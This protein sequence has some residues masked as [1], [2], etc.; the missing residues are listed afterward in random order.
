[1]KKL[2]LF[3]FI[4]FIVSQSYSQFSRYIIYFKNKDATTFSLSNPSA[5]LSQRSI[6]RRTKYAIAIDSSDLPVPAT[7]IL[8]VKNIAGVTVL[9][10]SRWLNAI[11]VSLSN[12][13]LL[14]Q[15]EAL[16]F[17]KKTNAIAARSISTET[18]T[19]DEMQ[20]LNTN[21]QHRAQNTEGNYF[22]YGSSSLSEMHLHKGEF[23]HNIG[24]RG[25][26]MQIAVIDGGFYQYNT[27]K[28][29]DSVNAN[30]QILDTWDFVTGDASV[31][32]D[33]SHGMSCL[34]TI[35]AN[36][37][38]QFIGTAPKAGFRLYRSEDAASE[39]PVEEFNFICAAERA[40]SSGVNIISC[41]LGY[42][43]FTNSTFNYTYADMN[44]DKTL[45][46][47]GADIAAKKG[48]LLFI[49]AGNSGNDA[50]K[51]IVTPADADSVLTV[52]AVNTAG[53]PGSFSSYG[54]SSDGRVKPDIASVGVSAIVQT[55]S[56]T[57][58]ISN[59]TSYACPKMAG[60]GT[61][62]WQGFPEFT[63]M[64]IVQVIKEAGS[65]YNTPDNRIGYGIPDMKKAFSALLSRFST[66]NA[67]INNCTATLNWT[68]KDVQGMRYEIERK[69]P[70]E[71]LYSKIAEIAAQNG[72]TLGIHNYQ[73][74][75]PIDNSAAG[76]ISYRIRQVIDTSIAEFTAVYIDTIDATL[77]GPCPIPIDNT[78]SATIAPNP[79]L[80]NNATLIIQSPDAIPSLHILVFDM[81]GTK[82]YQTVTSKGSGK[83]NL[84]IPTTSFAKG[85]YFV[86]VLDGSKEISVPRFL[87]L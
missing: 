24:L 53:I 23:L 45:A 64:Q 16:P 74:I 3:F 84:N 6:D 54:P 58:G 67:T 71:T 78:T 73:L 82:V 65:I 7:Y 12:N 2:L 62:L 27:Y 81:K 63:N 59:G 61:A 30:N 72:T 21:R 80:T 36:I 39:Y 4:F 76:V 75:Q 38:G 70:G 10:S 52:G 85:A 5:Y 20:D 55:S 69:I 50:W 40:D 57:V 51:Y 25:Q 31:A 37:P 11:S 13:N 14:A 83:I 60:L 29:F 87:K 48:L 47:I 22:D 56:N 35:A 32:E 44:G 77:S 19:E 49:A 86:K 28:A 43:T 42:N 17:V 68:S 33:I 34:S 46:A 8:Q 79:V 15:I 1:M 9:N 41:S 18:Y 66:A 26:G